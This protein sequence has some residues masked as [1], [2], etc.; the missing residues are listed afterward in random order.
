MTY[1]YLKIHPQA[2]IFKNENKEF[3]KCVTRE[4][5]CKLVFFNLKN[6]SVSNTLKMSM[7]I[8]NFVGFILK[9]TT[10]LENVLDQM[11]KTCISDVG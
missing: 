11:C 5:K 9:A 7:E 10:K 1:V 3:C 4:K 8:E 2:E 6:L